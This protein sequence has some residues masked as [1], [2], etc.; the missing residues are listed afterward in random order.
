ML[1]ALDVNEDQIQHIE[2]VMCKA[3]VRY[4]G[5]NE[6]VYLGSCLSSSEGSLPGVFKSAGLGHSLC[7]DPG[8]ATEGCGILGK[9][10]SS[11]SVFGFSSVEWVQS[12][13][14][15][16]PP[17]LKIYIRWKTHTETSDPI[18]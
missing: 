2:R 4:L 9:V 1:E 18:T 13:L 17:F 14:P 11:F 7:W 10:V 8:A 6:E 15:L 3:Q 12:C 5:S 16:L